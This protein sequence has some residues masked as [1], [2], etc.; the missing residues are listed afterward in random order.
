ML[1][2]IVKVSFTGGAGSTKV[3]SITI[4]LNGC[5]VAGSHCIMGTV[6]V[7]LLVKFTNVF[8]LS[9]HQG[10]KAADTLRLITGMVQITD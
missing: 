10:Y 1:K 3:V 8:S 2:E 7:M 9:M 6:I 5:I 4:V